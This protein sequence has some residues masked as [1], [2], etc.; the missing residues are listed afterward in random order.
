L[1]YK[2]RPSIKRGRA[3]SAPATEPVKAAVLTF[4]GRDTA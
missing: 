2:L 3:V 4:E 1:L